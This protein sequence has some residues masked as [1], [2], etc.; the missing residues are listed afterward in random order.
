MLFFLPLLPL[1]YWAAFV[2][3]GVASLLCLWA[4]CALTLRLV[5]APAWAAFGLLGA[6]ALVALP[7]IRENFVE[8][9][10]NVAVMAGVVA[11]WVAY[12]AGR[13]VPAGVCLGAAFALKPIPG[14]FFLYFL[15]K[16]EWRL[17]AAAAGALTFFN[18]AGLAL[19]GPDGFWLYATVNYPDHA[20]VWPAYPDNAS[21]RG[22]FTRLFGPSSWRRPPY[23]IA[24]LSLALWALAGA[25]LAG[26]AWLAAR[27]ASQAPHARP[28]SGADF[29]LAMLC[30]LSLLVA[31]IIWPHYYV[32]LVPAI[33]IIAAYLLP[34]AGRRDRWALAG[35]VAVAGATAVLATA[36]YG[37]PYRGVGGQ[38]LSALLVV[39]A[40]CLLA[41]WRRGGERSAVSGQPS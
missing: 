9:Q 30:T 17:L 21:L 25:T 33:V 18:L 20:A 38:Q 13:P 29:D 12:R 32:V 19:A 26:L 24:G 27:R 22:F 7:P 8:G 2:A 37:E 31:P 11:A 4:V 28:P 5:G 23:P 16:R 34:R 39:Y 40:V 6:L 3:W 15:W 36:H 10:L 14:L 1:S 35:C 41:L